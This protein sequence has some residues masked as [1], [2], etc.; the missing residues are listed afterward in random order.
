MFQQM[1]TP[2][3]FSGYDEVD[4]MMFLSDVCERE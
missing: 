1:K 4:F 2:F 3:F